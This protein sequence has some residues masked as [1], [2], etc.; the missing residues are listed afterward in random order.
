[1]VGWLRASRGRTVGGLLVHAVVSGIRL[2]ADQ[3]TSL[4][5]MARPDPQETLTAH[6]LD[7]PLSYASALQQTSKAVIGLG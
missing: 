1:M 6:S 7:S 4:V 5:P 3:L 2:I